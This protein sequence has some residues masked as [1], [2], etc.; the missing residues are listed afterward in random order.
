MQSQYL[1]MRDGVKIAVEVWLPPN[2]ATD[3]KAPTLV[4]AT[5]YSRGATMA[6]PLNFQS[7]MMIRLGQVD[8]RLVPI[9]ELDPETTWANEAGYAVVMVDARGSAASFGN[10]PIEWS[11]DEVA[12]YG[13][14][15]AWITEQPWSNGKVGAWGTSYPG[16]TAELMASTGQPGFLAAAPRF[17]DLDPLLGVGMPGGLRADGFLEQWSELNATM[18]HEISVAK[19]VNEDRNGKLLEQANAAHENPNIAQTMRTMKYR[20]D[21]YGNSGLT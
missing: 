20:D 8:P 12:D 17:S 4:E 1:T 10:R 11:P 18:D 9:V 19:P 2:L 3:E 7:K 13:E 21:E 5:R 15:I 16:N 6:Q 14:V